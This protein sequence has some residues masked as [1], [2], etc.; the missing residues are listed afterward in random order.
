MF[1]LFRWVNW[2]LREIQ[3]NSEIKLVPRQL[4]YSRQMSCSRSFEWAR[5][6]NI[7]EICALLFSSM[8]FLIKT[9]KCHLILYY[10]CSMVRLIAELNSWK[11]NFVFKC[12]KINRAEGVFKL[13]EKILTK[14]VNI[15]T[16]KTS[17]SDYRGNLHEFLVD[18]SCHF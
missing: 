3:A 11:I 6:Y 13:S 7:C 12:A 5:W 2:I 8:Q 14:F 17:E 4:Y 18:C 15:W 1:D 9:K 16:K 10:L